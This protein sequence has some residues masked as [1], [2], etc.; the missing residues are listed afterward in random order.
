MS[1][2]PCKNTLVGNNHTAKIGHV[3]SATKQWCNGF[4]AQA[5]FLSIKINKFTA[6]P[7]PVYRPLKICQLFQYRTAEFIA[8][9]VGRRGVTF[10]PNTP[11][12]ADIEQP[13]FEVSPFSFFFLFFFS[14]VGQYR[15]GKNMSSSTSPCVSG[16][17]IKPTPRLANHVHVT[18]TL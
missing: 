16:Q 13:G 3:F 6:D 2:V 7:C 4:R 11:S 14:R 8:V 9:G 12:T 5:E 17:N 1:I 15:Y 10:H 18:P